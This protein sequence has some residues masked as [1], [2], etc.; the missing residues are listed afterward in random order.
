MQCPVEFG[1]LDE[2]W[3]INVVIEIYLFEWGVLE[4][5]VAAIQIPESHAF[6]SSTKIR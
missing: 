5:C 6:E 4:I 1:T 3:L 2:N